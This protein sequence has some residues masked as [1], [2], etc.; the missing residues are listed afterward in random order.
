LPA[1]GGLRVSGAGAQQLLESLPDERY[2]LL[3]VASRGPMGCD[4]RDFVEPL[5]ELADDAPYIVTTRMGSD[6]A[7]ACDFVARLQECFQEQ[8][9]EV[10]NFRRGYFWQS[11]RIRAAD[12]RSNMFLSVIS[13]RWPLVHCY[14]RPHTRMEG[15]F[16]TRN[17]T[18]APAWLHLRHPSAYSAQTGSRL[19][20]LSSS[21]SDSQLPAV[22]HVNLN[23][24]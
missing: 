4:E 14:A 24:L 22:F 6:D 21:V 17:L 5:M 2:R 20:A 10:L 12:C 3:H 1:A 7:I 8:P 13:A 19:F 15:A 16:L 9:C 18:G 23:G 11:G